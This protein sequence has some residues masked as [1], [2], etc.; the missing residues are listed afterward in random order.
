MNHSMRSPVDW[1]ERP[2]RNKE[3]ERERE[4]KRVGVGAGSLVM[5]LDW[6]G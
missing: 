3:S 4:K 1:S 2:K 5:I 6:S